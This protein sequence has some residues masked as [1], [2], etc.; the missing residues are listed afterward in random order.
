MIA[1]GGAVLSPF[2]PTMPAVPHQFLLRNGIVAALSDAVVVIEAPARSGALNTAGWAADRIPVLAVPGDADRVHVA[3]CHALIRDG[4]ILAR[5][6]GDVLE[7]LGL[8]R[9]PLPQTVSVRPHDPLQAQLL[10]VL[11]LG[12]SD[13][14]GLVHA[15]GAGVAAVVS[16]LALL[17]VEG[18]VERRDAMRYACSSA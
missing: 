13:L 18:R 6:A 11:A 2:P 15:T 17:E 14:D 1:H 12:E 9:L 16:A 8:D 5:H 4:A 3:G 7:A 10:D